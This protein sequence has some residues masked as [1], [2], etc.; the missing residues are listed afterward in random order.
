LAVRFNVTLKKTL[1]VPEFPSATAVGV[2]ID[3]VPLPPAARAVPGTARTAPTMATRVTTLTTG[4]KN[5]ERLGR[6]VLM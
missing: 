1:V 5:R 2:L 3:H 4:A 6:M